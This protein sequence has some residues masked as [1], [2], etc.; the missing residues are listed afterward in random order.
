[1]TCKVNQGKPPRICLSVYADEQSDEAP[2][3]KNDNVKDL[4]I[5]EADLREVPEDEIEQVRGSDGFMYYYLE[6][7]IEA[8]CKFK[9]RASV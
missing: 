5:V 7:Q 8:L 3:A 6:G 4:A 2:L 9:P 1:M